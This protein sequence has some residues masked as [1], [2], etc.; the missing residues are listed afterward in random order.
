MPPESK[1]KPACSLEQRRWHFSTLLEPVPW[2]SKGCAASAWLTQWPRPRKSQR[3]RPQP[4]RLGVNLC[5]GR[6]TGPCRGPWRSCSDFMEGQGGPE[7]ESTS[8]RGQCQRRSTGRGGHRQAGP[9]P[10]G[11]EG[12]PA[13]AAGAGV[14]ACGRLQRGAWQI[15]TIAQNPADEPA[16]G[17]PVAQELECADKKGGFYP[18]KPLDG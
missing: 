15:L 18:R 2:R 3:Q 8:A 4:Q 5:V 14:A 9:G 16:L 1:A 10:G 17:A 7:R 13:G 11:D 12:E 6:P